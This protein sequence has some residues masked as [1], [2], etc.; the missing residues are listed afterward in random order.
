MG[1]KIAI[2][3]AKTANLAPATRVQHPAQAFFQSVDHHPTAGRHGAHEV[4]ELALDGGEVI[5]NIGVVKLEVVKHGSARPVMDKL[6]ALVKEGCVVFV[7]LNHEGR[8]CAQPGRHTKVERHTTNQEARLLA[9]GLQN[10]GQHGRGRGLPVGAGHGQHVALEQHVFCQ[11]LRAARVGGA[12]VQNRLHQ[13]KF[14]AAI[15]HPGAADDV[16]DHKHVG[17]EGKLIRAK[18]LDQIDTQGAQLLAHGRV[19][20][21]VATGYPVARLTRQR[22]QPTH[23]SAANTQNMNVHRR[24][25]GAPSRAARRVAGIRAQWQ[26]ERDPRRNC[27]SCGAPGGGGRP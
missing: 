8:A 26:H 14:R 12:G 15:G 5:K 13:R 21:C 6:A 3:R 4:V 23:K 17:L 16:T 25:L 7:G 27:R 9:G 11:P 22:R 1:G 24:I 2:G 20:T 19:N 18:T 10:P